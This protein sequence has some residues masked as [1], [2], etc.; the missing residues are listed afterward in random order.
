MLSVTMLVPFAR[1]RITVICGC[2]SVG[3]PGY[4]SV[5]TCVLI[6]RLFAVTRTASSEIS[7]WHPISSSF[8]VSDSRCFGMTLWI[9]TSPRVAAAANIYVPASI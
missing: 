2:I 1:P 3:N 4:G 6:S 8:A 7:T 9:V 5:L